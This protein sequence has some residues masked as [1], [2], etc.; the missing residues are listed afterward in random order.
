[1]FFRFWKKGN[2][3]NFVGMEYCVEFVDLEF[4]D[5]NCNLLVNYICEK[6]KCKL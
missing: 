1:M 6:K 2:F 4:N 5:V 3:D